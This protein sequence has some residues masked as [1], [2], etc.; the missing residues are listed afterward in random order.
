MEF[1]ESLSASQ[2]QILEAKESLVKI[3]SGK[4]QIISIPGAEK[5]T[6]KKQ[7]GSAFMNKS[8]IMA[9]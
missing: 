8:D 3:E 1:L 7:S 6:L 4:T 5:V 2:K 9:V